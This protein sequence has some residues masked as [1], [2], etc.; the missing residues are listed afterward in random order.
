MS[1]RLPLALVLV[2]TLAGC[3]S[4][5]TTYHY[6]GNGAWYHDATGADVVIERDHYH[7]GWGW[8]GSGYGSYGFHGPYGW[9]GWG[10]ASPWPWHGP[11][12]PWHGSWH[13]PR[14]SADDRPRVRSPRERVTPHAFTRE[15]QG[16]A[17]LPPFN[18]SSRRYAP[19][20]R[21]APAA[22]LAPAA[23]AA[24]AAVIP[25]AAPAPPRPAPSR[26]SGKE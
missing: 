26:N 15:A 10:L 8:W 18:A 22:R 21:P 20:L 16:P 5:G 24:R 7:D 11:Y 1:I 23:P 3:A 4:T 19:A 17:P 25:R 12:A 2:G 14:P 13:D 9:G 6:A